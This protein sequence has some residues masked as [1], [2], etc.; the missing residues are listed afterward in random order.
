M[1]EQVEISWGIDNY[2]FGAMRYAEQKLKFVAIEI[3]FA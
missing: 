2:L 3:T 1:T